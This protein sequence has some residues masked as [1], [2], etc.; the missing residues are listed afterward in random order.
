MSQSSEGRDLPQN[1]DK[2]V[3]AAYLR[4]LDNTQEATAKGVGVSLRTIQRWESEKEDWERARREAASRWLSDATDAARRAFL[5]SLKLGN[6][7]LAKWLLERVDEALLPPKQ[8]VESS[9]YQFNPADFTRDGLKRVAA[10]ESPQ[11]V[12]ATGGAKE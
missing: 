2:W 4:M 12:L 3:S 1:W 8:R 9:D 10:G 7:D 6:A 5:G 11:H